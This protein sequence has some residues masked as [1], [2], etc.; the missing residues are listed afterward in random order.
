MLKQKTTTKHKTK[1]LY[2]PIQIDDCIFNIAD[3]FNQ[4]YK[5]DI[6]HN[7]VFCPILQG[8]VPFFSDLIKYINVE[9]YVEYLGISSY[10]GL[11][12]GDFLV[13]KMP[14]PNL[15]KDKIVWIFDDIADTG[16]TLQFAKQ[17]LLEYG[18]LDVKTCTL[19]KKSICLF[20][21]DIYGFTL[22][23]DNWIHGYGLDAPN[24]RGRTAPALYSST[25]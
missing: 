10:K 13:Y 14:D 8:V 9:P 21:V 20:P 15:I 11:E 1:V 12:Q 23:N 24:G 7:L 16:N 22:K 3:H 6:E 25:I 2:N 17:T 19:L 5:K 4:K 18:A